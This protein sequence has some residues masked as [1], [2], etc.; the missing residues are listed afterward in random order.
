MNPSVSTAPKT[1]TVMGFEPATDEVQVIIIDANGKTL[2][3]ELYKDVPAGNEAQS[4]EVPNST[5]EVRVYS[6]NLQNLSVF[7]GVVVPPAGALAAPLKS[8]STD[9]GFESPKPNARE[10]SP[11]FVPKL[12]VPLS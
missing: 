9:A 11:P 8:A 5:Y 7:K 2:Y 12:T 6:N 10:H 3:N 1:I 4:Y